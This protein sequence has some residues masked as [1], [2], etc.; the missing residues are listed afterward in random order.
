[1]AYLF[2]VYALTLESFKGEVPCFPSNVR[3]G[4]KGFPHSANPI[5]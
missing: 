1:M 5:P 3:T 2:G 4:G